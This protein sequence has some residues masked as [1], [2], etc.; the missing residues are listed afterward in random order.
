MYIVISCGSD[1]TCSLC[2]MPN[3][4]AELDWNDTFLNADHL[5]ASFPDKT[6]HLSVTVPGKD[7]KPPFILK[8]SVSG[9][10]RKRKAGKEEQ[11]GLENTIIANP[12]I[13]P[14]RGPYSH[15]HPK[16]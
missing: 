3:Q 6:V 14:N 7:P 16:K 2:R 9:G 15:S 13:I 5:K 10:D 8:S 12:H 4:I 11:E 1:W